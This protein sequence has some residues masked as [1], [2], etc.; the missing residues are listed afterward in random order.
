MKN[1]IHLFII[2]FAL[3]TVLVSCK[4]KENTPEPTSTTTG[5]TPT[6]STASFSALF[7]NQLIY[8]IFGTSTSTLNYGFNNAFVANTDFDNF[9]YPVGTFLNVGTV[10]A[11]G[12]VFKNNFGYYMD[13][14]YNF[15]PSPPCTWIASGNAIPSFTYTNNDSYSTY[16]AYTTWTDTISKSAGLTLPLTGITNATEARIYLSVTGATTTAGTGTV[17]LSSSSSFSFS[18]SSLS[19]LSTATTAG[20]QIDFYRNNIQTINGKKMNFRNVTSYIKTVPVKN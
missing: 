3:S 11:N 17:V 4:K 6:A 14:T 1:Y 12:I 10:S 13:T 9:N 16:S 7:S 5:S 18:P 20:I 19:A 2:T 15:I 8:S